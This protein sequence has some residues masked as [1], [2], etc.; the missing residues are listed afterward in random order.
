MTGPLAFLLGSPL[1]LV[2]WIGNRLATWTGLC[3]VW[4]RV[5]A[6]PRRWRA[7]LLW[8]VCINLFS[9]SLLIG[10]LYWLAHRGHS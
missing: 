7:F 2:L 8:A 9:L 3:Y 1:K 6:S 5:K 4:Q 10:V